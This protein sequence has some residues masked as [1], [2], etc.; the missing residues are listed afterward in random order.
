MLFL[1][2][3]AGGR[4]RLDWSAESSLSDLALLGGTER[5]GLPRLLSVPFEELDRYLEVPTF[6]ER[7][8]K[9][10]CVCIRSSG[11]RRTLNSCS[12]S[13]PPP[14][15]IMRLEPRE[16]REKKERTSPTHYSSRYKEP[17]EIAGIFVSL[18]ILFS[19]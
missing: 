17:T 10:L 14:S 9:K 19:S 3:V 11:N 15:L 18:L 16:P 2:T 1:S 13:H 8:K 12:F 6:F 5:R 4:F 7:K